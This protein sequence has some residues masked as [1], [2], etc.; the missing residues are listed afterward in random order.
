MRSGKLLAQE[1][2]LGIWGLLAFARGERWRVARVDGVVF[3]EVV[4]S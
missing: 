4:L 2:G 1:I 3:L